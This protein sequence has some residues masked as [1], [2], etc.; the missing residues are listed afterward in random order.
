MGTKALEEL[1]DGENG[2]SNEDHGP[3]GKRRGLGCNNGLVLLTQLSVRA[4]SKPSVRTNAIGKDD[5][6][7]VEKQVEDVF[8]VDLGRWVRGRR[9]FLRGGVLDG[10]LLL[11]QPTW[12][13]HV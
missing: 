4:V 10:S 8:V 3:D 6:K 13:R 11:V 12:E 7:D 2:L 9:P 1:D 5:V